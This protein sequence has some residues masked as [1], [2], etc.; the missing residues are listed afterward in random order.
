MIEVLA[1]AE[2]GQLNLFNRLFDIYFHFI[3]PTVIAPT[4][5]A[6]TSVNLVTVTLNNYEKL[7][8]NNT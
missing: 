4:P 8:L 1:F 3:L 5:N 7:Q 2:N 6:K